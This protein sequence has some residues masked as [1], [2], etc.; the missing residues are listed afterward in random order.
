MQATVYDRLSAYQL[1][2]A[3]NGR[4]YVGRQLADRRTLDD[5]KAEDNEEVV[6]L[7]KPQSASQIAAPP[8]SPN[9][10]AVPS[11]CSVRQSD[12]QRQKNHR[13]A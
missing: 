2:L 12:K 5:F 8:K 1:Q 11:P 7:L 10:R 13:V 4:M 9:E 3:Y 6:R